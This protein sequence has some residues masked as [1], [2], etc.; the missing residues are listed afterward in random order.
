[1]SVSINGTVYSPGDQ[2]RITGKDKSD[3]RHS[4]SIHRLR[5][6]SYDE[7]REIVGFDRRYKPPSIVVEVKVHTTPGNGE[8]TE[9]MKNLKFHPEDVDKVDNPVTCTIEVRP[10]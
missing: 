4:A 7:T 2:I 1:M 8:L 6:S 9:R 5:L 3:H 10:L